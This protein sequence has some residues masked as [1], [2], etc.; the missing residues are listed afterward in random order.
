ME[1]IDSHNLN[2]Y[3]RPNKQ[4]SIAL[5][6][7]IWVGI[8]YNF[9]SIA[10]FNDEIILQRLNS[11]INNDRFKECIKTGTTHNKDNVITRIRLT[12]QILSG[13]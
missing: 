4:L 8:Y 9:D 6:D 3:F 12:K 11:I 10:K 13:N 2:E 5:L 7:S 1:F